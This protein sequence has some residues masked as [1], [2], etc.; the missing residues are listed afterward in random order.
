MTDENTMKNTSDSA[1]AVPPAPNGHA[2][3]NGTSKEHARKAEGAKSSGKSTQSSKKNK[4]KKRGRK[5]STP[6]PSETTAVTAEDAVVEA[7]TDDPTAAPA[8]TDEEQAAAEAAPDEG[9]QE[10]LAQEPVEPEPAG[11]RL[12]LKVWT[13]PSTAKRYLMPSGFM[14]DVVNGHPVSDIMYAYA[15][16]DDDT[17]IVTLTA[18]EWNALPF[19]YF[20]ENGAAPRASARRPDVVPPHGEAPPP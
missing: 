19:F 5:G 9:S 14:R 2:G 7:S 18:L 4:K 11:L 6:A 15:M 17:K 13:D 1:T 12:R 20:Q 16:S 8:E 10:P 3:S